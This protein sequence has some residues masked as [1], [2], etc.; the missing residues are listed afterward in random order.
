MILSTNQWSCVL[1]SF[2]FASRI[3]AAHLIEC[4][5]HDGTNVGFHT[6]ELIDPMLANGIGFIEIQRYPV[7]IH[8]TTWKQRHITFKDCGN[9]YRF[10]NY[11]YCSDGVLL[12]LNAKKAP[13]AVAWV[14]HN[15]HDPATGESSTLLL[16][17]S[18]GSLIGLDATHPFFPLTFLM[19]TYMK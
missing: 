18:Q 2:A 19:I 6:Q 15:I 16:R 10:A 3:S 17:G 13:H 8:P 7:A 1:D 11:L 9:D 14:K 4:I 12:G 5:G